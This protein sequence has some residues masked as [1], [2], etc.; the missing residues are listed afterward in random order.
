M[1]RGY[2]RGRNRCPRCGRTWPFDGSWQRDNR[3][4]GCGW[5]DP[6]ALAAA[7]ERAR[8][9]A[10]ARPPP[11]PPPRYV[12]SACRHAESRPVGSKEGGPDVGLIG[13]GLLLVPAGVAFVALGGV[14]AVVAGIGM[15]LSGLT[16]TSVQ[17]CSQCKALW[18]S[19]PESPPASGSSD[20]EVAPT[21]LPE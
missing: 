4:F 3:C 14:F 12:C 19:A 15:I 16:G 2:G 5:V 1:G 21:T 17:R 11:P 7:R 6:D 13:C 10:A 8:A 20:G 18:N 9:A